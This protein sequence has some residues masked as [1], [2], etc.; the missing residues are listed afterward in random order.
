METKEKELKQQL[1]REIAHVV[2]DKGV[3]AKQTE[4]FGIIHHTYTIDVPENGIMFYTRLHGTQPSPLTRIELDR[5]SGTDSLLFYAGVDF[6]AC[7]ASEK[8]YDT[9]SLDRL[10]KVA[11]LLKTI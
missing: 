9:I 8:Y 11:D 4:G 1:I 2:H 7:N 6:S 10:E 3:Y 5:V